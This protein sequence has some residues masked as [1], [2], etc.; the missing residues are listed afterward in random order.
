M[1]LDKFLSVSGAATRRDG[2]SAI[3]KGLVCVDGVCIR[4][5]ETQIDPEQ[6]RILIC[7]REIVYRK[8]VYLMMNKPAGI[9]SATD[10]PGERTVLDLLPDELRRLSLFPCGRLDK[11]TTGFVLL[12]NDGISAHRL[13]SPRHHVEKAYHFTCK[14]PLREEECRLLENGLTL[15][16]GY[17][18]KPCQITLNGEREGVIVLTEG[19]YHQ[20]K[21]MLEAVHNQIRTLKRIS[22]ASIPLDAELSSGEWRHL[23][24]QEL[25]T[26]MIAAGDADFKAE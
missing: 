5:P 15:D 8:Y 12:T 17:Q 20:I 7:G 6:Q 24:A 13:L 25:K 10:V 11:N 4:R 19:K 2:T 22:F 23:S 26:L 3:K 9:V 21:R 16:D 18:T 1:R 14:F